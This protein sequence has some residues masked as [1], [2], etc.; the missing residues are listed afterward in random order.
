MKDIYGKLVDYGTMFGFD[1][2]DHSCNMG[3]AVLV[4]QQH[5][6]CSRLE[7]ISA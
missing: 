1:E 2:R 4:P 6:G 3:H 5:A 7:Y